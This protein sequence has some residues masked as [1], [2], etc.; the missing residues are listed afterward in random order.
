[1]RTKLAL[2]LAI[3]RSP[4]LLILDEP[5]EGLDPVG[6]EQLLESLVSQCGDGTTSL[7]PRIKS[8]K[9]SGSPTGSAFWITGVC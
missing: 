9:S 3:S 2:L 6:V 4:K 1:M 7:F 5:S 8:K